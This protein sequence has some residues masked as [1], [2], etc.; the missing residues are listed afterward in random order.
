ME[1]E[2]KRRNKMLEILLSDLEQVEK[3]TLLTLKLFR[4]SREDDSIPYDDL[5]YFM[6]I[7]EI[8]MKETI[9]ELSKKK[10]IK[11][12]KG[13]TRWKFD[14]SSLQ[15]SLNTKVDIYRKCKA[16]FYFQSV[17]N[18]F[19]NES[20]DKK[21]ESMKKNLHKMESITETDANIMNV[22]NL[23]TYFRTQYKEIKG[24]DYPL[25]SKGKDYKLLKMLK[26]VNGGYKVVKMIDKIFKDE[27]KMKLKSITIG[28][29][30]G[31]REVLLSKI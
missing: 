20:F 7:D 18:K 27:S 22:D 9:L 4:E 12:D 24:K 19:E 3:L 5:E 6:G 29:L 25:T 13:V 1:M 2:R 31:F 15:E 26:E 23:F 21:V 10:L 14:T 28:A 17:K 8:T 11:I 16:G 30:W